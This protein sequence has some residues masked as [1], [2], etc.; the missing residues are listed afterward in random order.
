MVLIA[1]ATVMRDATGHVADVINGSTEFLNCTGNIYQFYGYSVLQISLF[2][3]KFC[4]FGLEN[5]FQVIELVSAWGPIIYAGCFAATLS[6]AL[7]SLV[8]AP[9]VFQ[10]NFTAVLP[11]LKL[12]LLV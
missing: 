4:E 8:S 2:P 3:G 5:S 1:G 7:A 10:V 11:D 12:L 6:S 9:K